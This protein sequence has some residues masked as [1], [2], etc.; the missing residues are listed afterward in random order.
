MDG[1]KESF[2]KFETKENFR[3]T[4]EGRKG[5]HSVKIKDDFSFS[6]RQGRCVSLHDFALG[7]EK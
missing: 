6:M 2:K 5:C 4:R 1:R 3:M 7:V